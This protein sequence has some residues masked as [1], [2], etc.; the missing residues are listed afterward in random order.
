MD[1]WHQLQAVRGVFKHGS[2]NIEGAAHG[3]L[4]QFFLTG[5]F[6]VPF[7]AFKVVNP[8][9]ISS[10]ITELMIQHRLFEVLR[11]NTLL[12]GTFSIIV[13]YKIARSLSSNPYVSTITFVATPVFMMLS[14]YFKYDIA[15]LF[16]LLLS[17]YF[18][19][20]YAE[21]QK[22]KTFFMAAIA[23]GLALA[24]KISALPLFPVYITAFILFT[25]NPKKQLKTLFIGLVFFIGIFF[26]F[27]IPDIFY[28]PGGYI[29]Y[30]Y[31][32]LVSVPST[33][34]DFITGLPTVVYVPFVLYPVLFGHP[35][36]FLYLLSTLYVYIITFKKPVKNKKL[37]FILS[38]LFFF[39]ISLVPLKIYATGN[40]ILVLLPFLALC[41]G[42]F[43]DYI[44]KRKVRTK[45]VLLFSFFIGILALQCF[46]IFGWAYVKWQDDP[47]KNASSWMIA[48]I[49]KGS[50]VGLEN[51]PIYQLVP[52]IVLYEFYKLQYNKN[53]KTR[54]NYKIIDR[55]SKDLPQTVILTNTS[56]ESLFLKESVKKL[57]IGRLKKEGYKEVA[58]F[59]PAWKFYKIYGNEREFILASIIAVFPITIYQKPYYNVANGVH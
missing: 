48:H 11:I 3:P 21:S 4:F 29:E 19:L 12:F 33:A 22:R 9:L 38:C 20:R 8:F 55:E 17:I 36:F 31:S 53:L 15:L 57:F 52:D 43:F 5:L 26:I 50:T 35:F 40:R 39:A 30:F 27:G 34:N 2:P 1:E 44:L 45:K 54:Y 49:P 42:I 25:R 59:D 23:S 10:S 13:F 24:T 47:R 41:T 14:T 32:N 28:Q 18:L 56:F 7:M 6:L 51:V 58:H 16:W 37:F 46:E